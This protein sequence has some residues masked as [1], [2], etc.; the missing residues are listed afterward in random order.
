MRPYPLKRTSL[1][2]N[3]K[4]IVPSSINA[5]SH[6]RPFT[7]SFASEPNSFTNP[8]T[9]LEGKPLFPINLTSSSVK[10]VSGPMSRLPFLGGK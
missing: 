3:V 1:A 4:V 10:V 2:K 6:G 5:T 9:E 7:A 8:D